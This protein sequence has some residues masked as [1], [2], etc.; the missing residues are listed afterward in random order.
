MRQ[1]PIEEVLAE[2]KSWSKPEA[3]PNKSESSPQKPKVDIPVTTKAAESVKP[4]VHAPIMREAA[5]S[6]A[7]CEEQDLPREIFA[8]TPISRNRH[9]TLRRIIAIQAIVAAVVAGAVGVLRLTNAEAY[10]NII[11]VLRGVSG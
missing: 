3:T 1:V 7:D 6:A 4:K 11:S 8:A 2:L 9:I 10:E 5:V